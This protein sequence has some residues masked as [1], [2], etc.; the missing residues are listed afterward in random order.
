MT[1]YRTTRQTPARILPHTFARAV[2]QLPQGATF[3][4]CPSRLPAWVVR[5]AG[6]YVE[7]RRVEV[8]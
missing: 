8:V 5:L 6:G 1:T 3:R 2:A 4:G 7:R